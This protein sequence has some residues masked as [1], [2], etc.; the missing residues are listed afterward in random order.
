MRVLPGSKVL[1]ISQPPSN[2]LLSIIVCVC[3][4]VHLLE[5]NEIWKCMHYYIARY[6]LLQVINQ[7][8]YQT[9]WSYCLSTCMGVGWSRGTQEHLS[10]ELWFFSKCSEKQ[11]SRWFCLDYDWHLASNM[12][13]CGLMD[14]VPAYGAG[15]CRFGSCQGQLSFYISLPPYTMVPSIIVCVCHCTSTGNEWN[16]KMYALLYCPICSFSGY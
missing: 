2:K 13:P 7:N 9:I 1:Y 6:A 14:K 3:V 15:D 4:T 12:W 10:F 11:P 8:G 5:M 16:M